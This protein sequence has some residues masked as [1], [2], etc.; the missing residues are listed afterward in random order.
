ML[1][2]H[3]EFPTFLSNLPPFIR[4]V[5]LGCSYVIKYQIFWIVCLSLSGRGD[6]QRGD[7]HVG[8]RLLEAEG[9]E[10]AVDSGERGAGGAEGWRPRIQRGAF[11]WWDEL[12]I[13]IKG[14]PSAD[15][16]ETQSSRQDMTCRFC[17]GKIW[18]FVY[19]S[20]KMMGEEAPLRQNVYLFVS[21]HM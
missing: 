9:A 21:S 13:Q 10:E 11:F 1:L 15:L 17:R 4:P 14:F 16:R 20:L 12:Y 2:G 7:W 19:S 3:G 8:R 5:C 6:H 18:V